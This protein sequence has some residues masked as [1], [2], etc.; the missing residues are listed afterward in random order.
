MPIIIRFINHGQF[1]PT[2]FHFPNIINRATPETKGHCNN[3]LRVMI[4][5]IG[6]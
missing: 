1:K 2:S 5:T 6:G 3:V 4:C